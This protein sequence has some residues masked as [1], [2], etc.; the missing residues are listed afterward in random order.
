MNDIFSRDHS[1]IHQLTLNPRLGPY[2]LGLPQTSEKPERTKRNLHLRVFPLCFPCLPR[3]SI[4]RTPIGRGFPA[5]TA[6]EE[7]HQLVTLFVVAFEI[8]SIDVTIAAF[9]AF[10]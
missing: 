5:S 8:M 1:P 10:V 4:G 9:E 7:P 3:G 6:I 2:L